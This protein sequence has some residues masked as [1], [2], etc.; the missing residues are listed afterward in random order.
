VLQKEWK[1]HLGGS[2]KIS[3]YKFPHY[4]IAVSYKY[5]SYGIEYLSDDTPIKI[6]NEATNKA[7]K[8]IDDFI[9]SKQTEN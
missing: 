5:G 7:R 3:V 1:K 8:F 4:T 2:G 9:N 6:K